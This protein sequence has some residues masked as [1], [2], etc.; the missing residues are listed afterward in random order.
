M[1]F[2]LLLL[3]LFVFQQQLAKWLIMLHLS[4]CCDI[5]DVARQGCSN[6]NIKTVH[7]SAPNV[8]IFITN[9]LLGQIETWVRICNFNWKL[10]CYS[11]TGC[12]VSTTANLRLCN[13]LV[14]F[15]Y[16]LYHWPRIV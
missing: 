4:W 3:L 16:Y 8:H 1:K 13:F 12:Q 10:S 5:M 11:A 7:N 2:S 15:V 14:N 6:T 9:Y